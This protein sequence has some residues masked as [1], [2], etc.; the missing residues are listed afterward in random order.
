MQRCTVY[1]VQAFPCLRRCQRELGSGKDHRLDIKLGHIRRSQLSK[2]IRRVRLHASQLHNR[3]IKV[4]ASA[5]RG[6]VPRRLSYAC[7]RPKLLTPGDGPLWEFNS[8]EQTFALALEWRTPAGNAHFFRAYRK[9]Q[10][11]APSMM[12]CVR[13]SFTSSPNP[14][15]IGKSALHTRR[16]PSSGSLISW[17]NLE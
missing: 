10:W 5:A 9:S 14:S 13:V 11:L 2:F 7:R 17:K 6:F 16:K 1:H 8:Q 3:D 4:V 15:D 12:V